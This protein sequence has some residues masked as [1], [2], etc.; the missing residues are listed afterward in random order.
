MRCMGTALYLYLAQRCADFLIAVKHRRRSG[1][2]LIRVR[3]TYSRLP[4]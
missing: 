2:R 4:S 3:L 1:F